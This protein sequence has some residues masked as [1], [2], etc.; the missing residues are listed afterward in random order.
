MTEHSAEIDVPKDGHTFRFRFDIRPSS[1][2]VGDLEYTDGPDFM[3]PVHEVQVRAWS[4][5]EALRKAAGLP[6][7]VR[8]GNLV[9]HEALPPAEG[10]EWP[11]ANLNEPH[12]CLT[13][14]VSIT[15]R[16]DYCRSVTS[17]GVGVPEEDR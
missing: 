16:C 2:I 5:T 15:A 9:S 7:N 14:G 1:R 10:G 6:S 8:M 3:G 12:T 11:C 4:L 13:E 17:P